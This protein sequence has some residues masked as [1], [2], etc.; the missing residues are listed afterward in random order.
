MY[1]RDELILENKTPAIVATSTGLAVPFLPV[2]GDVVV[3]GDESYEVVGRE[4]YLYD[5]KTAI[6]IKLR[7]Q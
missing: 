5:N 6:E 2:R 1:I 3:V 4:V 7:R